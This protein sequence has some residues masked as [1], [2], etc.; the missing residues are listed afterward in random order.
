MKP[1]FMMLCGLPGSGKSRFASEY[2]KLTESDIYSSDEIRKELFGDES[3]QVNNKEVFKVLHQ[4]IKE[5]LRSNKSVIYDATNISSKRRRAFVSEL[6]NINCIKHCVVIATPYSMCIKNNFTR[7]RKVP[8][9]VIKRMYMN[10]NTPFYFEGWDHISVVKYYEEEKSMFEWYCKMRNYKQD[11]THHK[12]TLGTHCMEVARICNEDD[13]LF[14]AGCVHDCGKPFTKSFLNS[15][16]EYTSE[17]HYY[18]HQN[19]GAYDSLMFSYPDSIKELDVS[20]L[21]NLHMQ[22]FFWEK[23]SSHREK[24]VNKYKKLWGERLFNLVMDLHK[25]DVNSH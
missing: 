11:N 2:S 24:T 20:I 6:K 17:A 15:K 25:A 16:G 3:S 13:L 1:I 4:R 19:V 14:C 10:W 7:G 18:N 12:H 21:V 5:S 9:D 23:D 8:V 22:P